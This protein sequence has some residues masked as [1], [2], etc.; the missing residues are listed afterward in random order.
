MQEKY[1]ELFLL[2]KIQHLL[3]V[4]EI[5]VYQDAKV[6]D[7]T[8]LIHFVYHLDLHIFQR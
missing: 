4:Q 5:Q 6:E 7:I 1:S 3:Q 2:L 8:Q